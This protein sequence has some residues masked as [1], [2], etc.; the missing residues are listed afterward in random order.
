MM[1]IRYRAQLSGSAHSSQAGSRDLH[2][3]Q[4]FLPHADIFLHTALVN[5]VLRQH[6]VIQVFPAIIS[7]L[8]NQVLYA[9]AWNLLESQNAH[10]VCD[11]KFA[12]S[13]E[14]QYCVE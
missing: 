4:Y 13:V 8:L 6:P 5:P 9:L 1:N 10:F 7:S 12:C 3:L 11:V 2:L 14:V